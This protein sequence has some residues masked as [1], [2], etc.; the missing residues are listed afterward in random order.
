MLVFKGKI[1]SSLTASFL[2]FSASGEALLVA[3]TDPKRSTTIEQDYTV[4]CYRS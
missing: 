4:K 1:E 3:W 2:D